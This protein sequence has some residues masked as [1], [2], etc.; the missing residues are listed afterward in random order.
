MHIEKT[1]PNIIFNIALMCEAQPV[2]KHLKLKKILNI[3]VATIY[4]S[5]NLFLCVTGIGQLNMATAIAFMAGKNIINPAAILINIGIAGSKNY[6][7]GDFIEVNKISLYQQNDYHH[8]NYYPVK[9]HD[10]KFP[11]AELITYNQISNIYRDNSLSDMEGYGFFS[12]A[13]KYVP[14]EQIWLGKIISDNNVADL[15]KII[16]AANKKLIYNQNFIE[17]LIANQLHNIDKLIIF[18]QELATN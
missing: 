17:K 7:I 12:A 8:Y 9:L 16:N 5:D 2:I 15:D 1:T 10:F 18:Y 4:R 13:I 14:R 3:N 6:Q 11:E